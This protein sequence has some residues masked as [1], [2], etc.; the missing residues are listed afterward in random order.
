MF[1]PAFAIYKKKAIPYFAA[2]IQHSLIGDLITGGGIQMLWPITQAWYGLGIPITSLGNILLEW[3]SF[4]TAC[5]I[6]LTTKDMQKLLSPRQFTLPLLVPILT[7]L[8]PP[9]L[10]FPMA[11]PPSLLVPHLVYLGLFTASLLI[12]FKSTLKH[13][14]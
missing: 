2:L 10:H 12:F 14:K 3:S 5:V 8:L 13:S 4:L 1:I 7:V 11:V 9:F 6:M